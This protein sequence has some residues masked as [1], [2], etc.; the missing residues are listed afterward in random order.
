MSDLMYFDLRRHFKIWFSCDP[1]EWI[2]FHNQ[3]RLKAFLDQNPHIRLHFIYSSDL[4]NESAHAELLQFREAYPQLTL[5]NMPLKDEARIEVF[6]NQYHFTQQDIELYHYARALLENV[7]SESPYY[8]ALASDLLRWLFVDFGIYSDLDAHIKIPKYEQ[9]DP[10]WRIS[11]VAPLQLPYMQNLSE[12]S[13]VYNNDI[14]VFR[15]GYVSTVPESTVA[16]YEHQFN[17][18]LSGIKQ[19]LLASCQFPVH[20]IRH[21]IQQVSKESRS[22]ATTTAQSNPQYSSLKLLSLPNIGAILIA[23]GKPSSEAPLHQFFELFFNHF[24]SARLYL[25]HMSEA[26]IE[27]EDDLADEEACQRELWNIIESK[28]NAYHDVPFKC[29]AD[30][31]AHFKDKLIAKLVP[32]LTGSPVIFDALSELEINPQYCSIDTDYS[33]P[34]F[35]HTL[36]TLRNP[37]ARTDMYWLP[38]ARKTAQQ[39]ERMMFS[40]FASRASKEET[41]K[42]TADNVLH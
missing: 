25:K 21:Y 4:L 18:I 12:N 17:Q 27:S 13:C 28:G 37:H 26:G 31:L 38:S 1:N 14:I 42:R 15:T 7:T 32:I 29:V 3:Y 40:F 30:Y 11:M 9:N 20:Q 2:N 16:Q 8:T 41:H 39:S 33:R 24:S 6:Q 36:E 10:S 22:S 35:K 19:K 23:M 5:V 34:F